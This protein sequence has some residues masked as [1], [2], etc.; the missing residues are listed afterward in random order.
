MKYYLL[1]G[2]NLGDREGLIR[3][4]KSEITKKIGKIIK[5]SSLYESEP[6]GFIAEQNFLNQ[7]IIVKSDLEP[8]KV[9][10]LCQEIENDLGRE[11]SKEGYASRTMDIDILFI[12]DLI[13][14][15]ERLIVPHEHLH[16]RRFTLLPLDELDSRYIHPGL[17]KTIKQLLLDCEDKSVVKKV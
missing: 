9:L 14:K 8:L 6:W 16:K 12:D 5:E 10:D 15:S 17:N 11:R 13:I 2:G 3:D 4:S 7:V 1:L